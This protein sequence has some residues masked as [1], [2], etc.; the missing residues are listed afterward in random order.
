M[1]LRF[2]VVS[3]AA[4]VL[5]TGTGYAQ[6]FT[7]TVDGYWSYN[8]NTPQ[9]PDPSDPTKLV[10]RNTYRAFDINDQSFSMNYA[11]LAIDYK[12]NNVGVRVDVGFGDAAD[13]VSPSGWSR[14][15]QQAYI[16]ATKDKFTF[17][18]GKFVTP[19]GA[20]VIETKDNWN[21]SRGLLFTL[22]IPFTHFGGRATYVANDK[23]S[24]T[25]YLVNGW[26]NTTDEN[27]AK[28]IGFVGTFKPHSKISFVT[29]YLTGKE[30]TTTDNMRHLFDGIVTFNVTDRLTLMGNV[31][32]GQDKGADILPGVSGPRVV[33][34]GIAGYAKIK[35]HDKLTL[36]G[37][38]EW[39]DD[40]DGY[41][42]GFTQEIQSGTFTAQI[43]VV[44]DLVIWG[45]F[46]QDWSNQSTFPKT[47][48]GVFAPVTSLT[49]HQNTFLIGLTYSFTK[50]VN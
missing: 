12:P 7:G 34:Q 33:W 10:R 45:E 28:S 5:F 25:G 15:I 27:T 46:R 48:E 21:Y 42:T 26:D 38:Y 14:R 36:S 24:L 47:T 44:S 31:D 43:P 35:A 18:F 49:D 17:D 9:I 32:Y 2:L 22:A 19:I 50:T 1:R 29:N 4:L 8:T 3:I 16:T 20:E 13:V 11:E 41:R 37:R 6:T 23:V 40:Q 30:G 39:F